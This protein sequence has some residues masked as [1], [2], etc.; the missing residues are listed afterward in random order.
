[1]SSGKYVCPSRKK[2]IDENKKKFGRSEQRDIQ[3]KK[4]DNKVS[5]VNSEL[6]FPELKVDKKNTSD[7]KGELVKTAKSYADVLENKSCVEVEQINIK[8]E[9]EVGDTNQIGTPDKNILKYIFPAAGKNSRVK[10]RNVNVNVNGKDRKDPKD[11]TN[12]FL[13]KERRYDKSGWMVN[14]DWI[15]WYEYFHPNEIGSF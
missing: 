8:V 11:Q 10:G 14:D 9:K 1:M 5:D 7:V 13:D 4:L 2:L 6:E 3:E 12:N 15:F